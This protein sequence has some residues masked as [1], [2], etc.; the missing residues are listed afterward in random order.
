MAKL[1]KRVLQNKQ[2]QVCEKKA[3]KSNDELSAEM[4]ALV[5]E[6]KYADAMDVMAE[7]AETGKMNVDIMYLGAVCYYATGDYDRAARWVNNVLTYDAAHMEAKLLLGRICLMEDRSEA[8]LRILDAA[9]KGMAD[10]LE[11]ADRNALEDD[12]Y[13]YK[14]T[15]PEELAKYPHIQAF[16]GIQVSSEA[17]AE[18][19]CAGTA[20]LEENSDITEKKLDT[21][22]LIAQIMAKNVDLKEKISMLNV[23]AAGCYQKQDYPAAEALLKAALRVDATNKTLLQNMVYVYAANDAMEKAMEVASQIPMID[24]ACLDS[25][26]R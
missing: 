2:Q 12:L 8:G 24:F 18:D 1:K 23:F 7:I 13:Y 6:E 9:L 15:S 19:N 5:R 22:G 11:E 3:A 20:S 25:M 14:Y 21:D 17:V 26:K 16:L 10:K 4:A